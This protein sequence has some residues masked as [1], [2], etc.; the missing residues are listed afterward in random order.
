M[1]RRRTQARPRGTASPGRRRVGPIIGWAV[2]VIALV[3]LAIVVGRPSTESGVEAARSTPTPEAALSIV[4]GT[5]L[6]S[7]TNVASPA[8]TRFRSGDPFAYS[9]TLDHPP[10][11][12]TIQV[13]VFRLESPAPV[14]VQ[15]PSDE[16]ILPDP[17]T[18]GFQL[19]TD[20]LL[21]AWGP[22]DYEMRIYLDGLSAPTAVGRFTLLASP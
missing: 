7:G 14:E 16:R 8:E 15:A 19:P 10:G 2:A 12:D 11:T 13:Q 20:R 3:A 17:L 5:G 21:T 18:F 4:F 22:G 6:H 9:V 1:V